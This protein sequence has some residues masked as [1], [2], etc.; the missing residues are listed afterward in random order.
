[1]DPILLIALVLGLAILVL[2]IVLL[3]RKPADTS[4]LREEM[5]A[6][7]AALLREFKA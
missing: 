4:A 3:L 1:M 2:L 5:R 7:R 6:L